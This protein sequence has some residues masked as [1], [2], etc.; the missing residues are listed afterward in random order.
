VERV[1]SGS[2]DGKLI[3]GEEDGRFGL[4]PCR[5]EPQMAQR[6]RVEDEEGECG[7]DWMEK[8]RWRGTTAV[9]MVR[10]RCCHGGCAGE[11]SVGEA[12]EK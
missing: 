6:G 4:L 3:G 10:Q 12:R 7:R 9:E 11:A 8:P 1:A 5:F 2:R